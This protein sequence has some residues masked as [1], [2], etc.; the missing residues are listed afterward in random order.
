MGLI[1]ASRCLMANP[2]AVL[3]FD[4]AD[5]EHAAP[6]GG[7]AAPGGGAPPGGAEPADPAEA[8][9]DR[10]ELALERAGNALQPPNPNLSVAGAALS[11]AEAAL[12]DLANLVV[13]PAL[14]G[15]R[16]LLDVRRHI[17]FIDY[18]H[19]KYTA[20]F[21]AQLF[22]DACIAIADATGHVRAARTL[23]DETLMWILS[24]QEV[25]VHLAALAA[26]Y[27]TF[28]AHVSIL[29][30]D[31]R[32][33]KDRVDELIA[34]TEKAIALLIPG[35]D[36][37]RAH[38]GDN[39]WLNNHKRSGWQRS[40]PAAKLAALQKR[41]LDLRGLSTAQEAALAAATAALDKCPGGGGGPAAPGA[42]GAAAS[43]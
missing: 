7:V 5:A 6:P 15:R 21:R 3:H 13:P 2:F 11:D 23:L 17:L 41:L 27:E 28:D 34:K 25:P 4:D 10:I 39:A 8:L 12:S 20:A 31:V 40:D 1:E 37:A 14:Q 35:R 22:P 9:L 32:R 18:D 33:D 36:G 43:M 26:E 42:G 38:V 30:D 16:T 29:A 19:L 24:G